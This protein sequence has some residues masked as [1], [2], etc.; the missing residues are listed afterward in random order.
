MAAAP[1]PPPLPAPTVQ[2]P[3]PERP[4]RRR[5]RTTALIL[6][7]AVL[8]AAGGTAYG[9]TVQADRKPT[10]LPALSQGEVGYPAKASKSAKSA[11]GTHKADGD[12]RKLLVPRPSGAR[13]PDRPVYV[14]GALFDR[15][16]LPIRDYVAEYREPDEM[17]RSLNEMGIRRVAAAEWQQ[18]TYRHTSVR[19]VQFAADGQ[20]GAIEHA[21]QQLTYMPFDRSGAGNKGHGFKGTVDGRYFLYPVENKPGYLPSYTARA[22]AYRGDVMV[23]VHIF[24]TRPISEKDIR[25]LVER[26]VGRL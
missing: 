4:R 10:P 9:Y 19:L 25:S 12:L 15:G 24:D 21:T 18:G 14:G 3:A 17:L 22:L 2:P 7:A 13:K 11:A 8:G 5:G 6:A 16:W 23:D 26:Q 20:R 1:P